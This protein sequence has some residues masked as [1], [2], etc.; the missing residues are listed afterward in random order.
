MSESNN[1]IPIGAAAIKLVN[2]A[3]DRLRPP[4]VSIFSSAL[5]TCRALMAASAWSRRRRNWAFSA[6]SFSCVSGVN[7]KFASPQ[8]FVN[9]SRPCQIGK[10]YKT[11]QEPVSLPLPDVGFM[12]QEE[13]VCKSF[14]P[15]GCQC[16]STKD[17]SFCECD[18]LLCVRQRLD[19]AELTGL[20]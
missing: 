17:T 7:V 6:I 18:H 20:C 8:C 2:V 14:S 1:N 3:T 15:Q 13:L 9:Q 19:L 11:D 16:A 12:L 5:L 4:L 10:N